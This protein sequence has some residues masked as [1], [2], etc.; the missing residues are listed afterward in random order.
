MATEITGTSD[1]GIG[2][3]GTSE[4]GRGLVG[5][6]K[7][8]AGVEGNSSSGTGVFG[9][10]ETGVGV[11]G[12]GGR[13]AALLEGDVEVTGDITVTNQKV[14]VAKIVQQVSTTAEFSQRIS[15]I[16]Q[17]LATLRVR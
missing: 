16:E 2:V 15:S 5:V 6:A 17:T 1:T 9:N 8:F 12:K 13:L 14:S 10:S 7:T 3:Y 11:H 4:S